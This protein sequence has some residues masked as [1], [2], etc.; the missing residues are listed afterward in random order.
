MQPKE[1]FKGSVET[2]K[3]NM[4]IGTSGRK[5]DTVNEI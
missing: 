5:T 1:S 2:S 3:V 4:I